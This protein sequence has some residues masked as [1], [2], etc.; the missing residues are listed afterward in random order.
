MDN[1]T[2]DT[3]ITTITHL[4]IKDAKSGEILLRKRT[5]DPVPT[6]GAKIDEKPI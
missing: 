2:D 5:S 1:L 6:Q 3:S 4:V